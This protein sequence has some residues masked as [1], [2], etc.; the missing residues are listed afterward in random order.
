MILNDRWIK[1][2][3]WIVD[4]F[5]EAQVN[6]NSYDLTWSGRV[7]FPNKSCKGYPMVVDTRDR[8]R[9]IWE[10]IQELEEVVIYPNHICL[11]DTT[12]RLQIPVNVC[13]MLMLKSSLGRFGFEHLHAGYFDSGFGLDNPSTATLEIMNTF[14][15]PLKIH[16]GQPIVQMVF[17]EA[18]VPERDYRV[19]GRYQ[20]QCSPQSPK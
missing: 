7:A 12:E 19:T 4:P 10:D 1:D 20:G 5:N 16:K 11:L 14:P 18:Q 15:L 6:P 3:S 13:G 8:S 9:Q 17:M 2:N